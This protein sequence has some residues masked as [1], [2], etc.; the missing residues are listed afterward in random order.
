MH[1]GLSAAP[2]GG[3]NYGCFAPVATL[4]RGGIHKGQ[5]C[6]VGSSEGAPTIPFIT[7]IL[8]TVPQKGVIDDDDE[9]L[10]HSWSK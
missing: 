2:A 4:P 8:P 9:S 1:S 5:V 3:C 6:P 7:A 10:G